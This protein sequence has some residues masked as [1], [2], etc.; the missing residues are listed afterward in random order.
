MK[1]DRFVTTNTA[2]ACQ[3]LK[4]H[5]LEHYKINAQ[6]KNQPTQD[7]SHSKAYQNST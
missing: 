4:W 2:L 5:L 3:Q 1:H 6:L 7:L